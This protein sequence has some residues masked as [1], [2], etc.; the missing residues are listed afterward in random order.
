[1]VGSRRRAR[2]SLQMLGSVCRTRVSQ[3]LP[4]TPT[5]TA[6]RFPCRVMTRIQLIVNTSE[7]EDGG[8]L[9]YYGLFL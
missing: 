5:R 4:S 3:W 2:R 6:A 7:E 9:I 1:M 8:A